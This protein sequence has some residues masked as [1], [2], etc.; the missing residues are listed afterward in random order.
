MQG[1]QHPDVIK[2]G[3]VLA[4]LNDWRAIVFVMMFLI[5]FMLI[6]RAFASFQMRKERERM[7]LVADKF[8]QA[9]ESMVGTV[10]ELKTELAVLRAVSARVESTG[11]NAR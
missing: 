4:T 5:A 9:A 7:W 1:P 11:T 3:E 8:G 10:N 6:E 2:A